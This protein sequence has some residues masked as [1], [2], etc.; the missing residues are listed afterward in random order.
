MKLARR[1]FDDAVMP[2]VLMA[3]TFAIPMFTVASTAA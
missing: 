2:A 3:L 1:I